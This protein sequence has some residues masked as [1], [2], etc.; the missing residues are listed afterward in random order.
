MKRFYKLVT[1]R[2]TNE[3][4]TIN[5]DGKPVKTPY[6]ALLLTKHDRL[7]NAL[8]CEWESQGEK[9][10]P[11]TMPLTQLLSTQID[12]VSEQRPAMTKS[13]LKY[14]D[15]DLICYY[16][17]KPSELVEVQRAS[18][19]PV[20]ERFKERFGVSLKTTNSLQALSQPVSAHTGVAEY[21]DVLD[22]A[23]F[24]VVQLIAPLVGSIIIAI[25]FVEREITVEQTFAAMRIE[26]AYKAKIYNEAKYGMDPAEQKKDDA[27]KVD[28]EASVRFLELV[29]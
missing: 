18:W 20:Q 14:L 13:L 6:K 2:E 3:G 12:R 11:D 8:V 21:I 27:V 5:L 28:L 1:I 15:T 22:S 16:A 4:Y 10:I 26:E 17:D 23:H 25:A 24:T 7:A 19:Q 29:N 9:I